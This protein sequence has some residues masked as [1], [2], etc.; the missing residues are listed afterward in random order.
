VRLVGQGFV[1]S[2]LA[3]VRLLARRHGRPAVR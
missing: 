2:Q 3:L 1:E